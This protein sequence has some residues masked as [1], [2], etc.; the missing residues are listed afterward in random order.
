MPY[1]YHGRILHVNLNDSSYQIEEPSENFYRTYVGGGGLGAYYLLKD[2]KPGT[3]PLGADNILVVA[4]SVV[5]G[6]PLS[7]FSRYTIAAKSPLTGGFAETEAGGLVLARDHDPLVV[8]ELA[9]G[10]GHRLQRLHGRTA[11]ASAGGASG[12]GDDLLT[13]D[14]PTP[15]VTSVGRS[16]AAGPISSANSRSL[17]AERAAKTNLQPSRPSARAVAA[18]IPELAPMMIAR[19]YIASIF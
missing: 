8:G 15:T 2:L 16:S 13:I 18:P 3:D 9:A 19:L 12:T 17:P 4:L 1:G 11:P 6:A 10:S 14:H 7:G 5:T